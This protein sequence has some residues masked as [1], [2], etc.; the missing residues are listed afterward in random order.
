MKAILQKVPVSNDASFAVRQFRS[1]YFDAPWHFHPE[2]ELVLIVRGK[3]SGS[4][5]TA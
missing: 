4:W 1:A 3:A 2:H 5:A